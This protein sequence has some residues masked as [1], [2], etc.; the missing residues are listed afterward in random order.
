MTENANPTPKPAPEPRPP[1]DPMKPQ[2]RSAEPPNV[3]IVS[4]RPGTT[5]EKR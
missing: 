4:D 3:K 2:T 5:R 1:R